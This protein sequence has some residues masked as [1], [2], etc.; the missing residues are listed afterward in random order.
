MGNGKL[1]F[2]DIITIRK[3]ISGVGHQYLAAESNTDAN[4]NRTNPLQW[5]HFMILN[6]KYPASRGFVYHEDKI[7]LLSWHGKFLSHN[8]S[9]VQATGDKIEDDKI[10]TITNNIG[11][12]ELISVTSVAAGQWGNINLQASNNL[13][14]DRAQ[15]GDANLNATRQELGFSIDEKYRSDF[16]IPQQNKLRF[17][18]CCANKITVPSKYGPM[19]VCEFD[20]HD[21]IIV[22]LRG[23]EGEKGYYLSLTA[24]KPQIWASQTVFLPN[25][26][27]ADLLEGSWVSTGN[28]PSFLVIND[29]IANHFKGDVPSIKSV[30]SAPGSVFM[31]QVAIGDTWQSEHLFFSVK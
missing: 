21:L 24:F 27:N 17:I 30:I 2:G 31:F 14:L 7:S 28:A 18:N 20:R 16:K 22:D 25:G 29:L 1:N 3:T 5:E 13:F 6:A 10:W 11:A 26:N 15:N 19:E 8:G 12:G 23:I 9:L 4:F